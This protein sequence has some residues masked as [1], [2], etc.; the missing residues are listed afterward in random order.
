MTFS[1]AVSSINPT[2]NRGAQ[3]PRMELPARDSVVRVNFISAGILRNTAKSPSCL[4]ST[5][6]LPSD[7]GRPSE[8]CVMGK[9]KI[10]EQY[11]R[12]SPEDQATFN[13]WLRGNA[14]F[15]SLIAIG[16]T[17]MAIAGYRSGV[18]QEVEVAGVER[19]AADLLGMAPLRK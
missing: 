1:R 9:G 19:A 18:S 2:A 8:R 15:G 7:S 10:A 5:A 11:R 4:L 13:R 14:V 3:V 12:L 17:A 6:N 16:L